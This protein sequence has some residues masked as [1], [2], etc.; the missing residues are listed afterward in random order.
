MTH[1]DCW[2][3]ALWQGEASTWFQ[4][5]TLLVCSAA[6]RL[7]IAEQHAR[8]V[9][10]L[11]V[12]AGFA[13]DS[14]LLELLLVHAAQATEQLLHWQLGNRCLV[15]KDWRCAR[16]WWGATSPCQQAESL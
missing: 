16:N 3:A 13:T 4:S 1:S 2:S 6:V 11:I 10:S 15:L 14:M 9:Q 5:R 12:T 8:A 7:L